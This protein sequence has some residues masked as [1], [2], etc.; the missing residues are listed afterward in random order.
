MAHMRG[1]RWVVWCERHPVWLGWWWGSDYYF[2]VILS[3]T[4]CQIEIGV[5]II[6]RKSNLDIPKRSCG[7]EWRA[8]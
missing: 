6:R 1:N 3:V 5:E 7:W 8:T 4:V 2:N